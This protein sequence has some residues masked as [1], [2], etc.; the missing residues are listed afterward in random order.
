MDFAIAKT[1]IST[2]T[3]PQLQNVAN[4]LIDVGLKLI[5]C[6]DEATIVKAKETIGQ[7]DIIYVD[8]EVERYFI[9]EVSTQENDRADKINAFFS[10]WS[11]DEN[12]DIVKAKFSFAEQY[13]ISRIFFDLSGKKEI[14]ESVQYNLGTE[15]N[16]IMLSYD[17]EYF[18]D[19]YDKVGQWAKNDFFNFIKVK[20][21][22]PIMIGNIDAIQFYLGHTRAYLYLDRVDRILKYCYISRRVRNDRGYQR[23]LEK[24]RIGNIAK[25]IER[26]SLLA[27]PNTILISSPDDYNFINNPIEQSE[28]PK[29]V[30]ISIPN[31]FCACRI[32][33][34]QH[35]LLGF[36]RLDSRLQ[37][38]YYLPIIALDRIAQRDEMKT[39]I[40]INSTQKKIDRN[41]ILTLI[42]DFTWDKVLNENEYYEKQA[43]EVVKKLNQA[44]TL[45]DKIF[46]PLALEKRKYK[47]TLSTLVSAILGNNFVGWK[48]HL[49]QE[50]DGDLETPYNKIKKIFLLLQQHLP[51]YTSGENPFF[52]SN[53]GL[54]M[55]FRFLQIFERNRKKGNLKC[56]YEI[57]IKNLAVIINENFIKK[58]ENYYGEGGAN[59]AA[60]QVW[61]VFKKT[62]KRY[63]KVTTN[64]KKV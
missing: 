4:F 62:W 46:I 18:L 59:K 64:L 41:L 40:E 53:K 28:C 36:A 9:F 27:F 58:L 50:N 61:A 48:L 33:D 31:Y 29:S 23:I 2:L 55:F 52:L 5:A 35:R 60:D 47:I 37:S 22:N 42:A 11:N 12:L 14:P 57:L 51:C 24:G 38:S 30:K 44:S 15:D 49:F 25:K 1:K 10:K 20:P 26:G 21:P 7:L 56:D 34:G 13:K 6:G 43:V 16:S 32:I 54:R 45:K 63:K 8:D 19:A 17:F 39:F 3:D